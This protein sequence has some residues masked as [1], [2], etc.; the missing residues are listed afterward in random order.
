MNKNRFWF[1][2]PFFAFLLSSP[3]NAG[4]Y[5]DG[6][7]LYSKCSTSENFADKEYCLGYISGTHDYIDG[8]QASSGKA[9]CTPNQITI[10]QEVDVVSLY[11]KNNPKLRHFTASSL[12]WLA[13]KDAFPC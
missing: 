1:L 3:A 8:I 12:V 13:L 5:V 9:I 11:L 7:V 6:N 4:Y 10:G 2:I